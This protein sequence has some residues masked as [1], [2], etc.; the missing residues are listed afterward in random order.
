MSESK[1]KTGDYVVYPSH[2]VGKVQGVEQKQIAGTNI[3]M[4]VLSFDDERMVLRLPLAKTK[5]LRK[6]ATKSE[7][8]DIFE[9]L[10]QPGK[11]KKVMWSRRAREYEEKINSGSVKLLAEVVRDLYHSGHNADQS[12]SEKQI[13]NVAIERLS[14]E[15]AIVESLEKNKAAEKLEKTLFRSITKIASDGISNTLAVTNI[16]VA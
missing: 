10:K 14:R 8:K 15:F 12:Y 2:G 9:V 13:Y 3:E 7:L 4:L 1:Y 16:A 11:V 6:V 5:I